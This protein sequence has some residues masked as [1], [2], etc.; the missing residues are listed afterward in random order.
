M[1]TAFELI[2]PLGPDA[3]LLAIDIQEGF[4]DEGYWG[5]RNNPAGEANMAALVGLWQQTGRP[6]VAVRHD[7]VLPDSPLR[8]CA[9]GNKLLPFM[10]TASAELTV[11]KTVNSAF[12][13]TPDL[14]SWLRGRSYGQ[15]VVCGIQ[16]NLCCE[17]T[18]RMAGN[19]G[20][21]VLFVIDATHT[22]DLAGPDGIVVPAE[23]LT[24]ATAAN[25]HG[26]GFARVVS[27]AQVIAAA[28]PLLHRS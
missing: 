28:D 11:S 6:L 17:T 13:G 12:Y 21:D 10:A 5:R 20:Y 25:L 1:N 15:L 9:P 24:R 2:P 14:D 4:G 19:L 3:V 16:T 23:D 7:S 27:T 22:Y 26:D 8:P 18:A